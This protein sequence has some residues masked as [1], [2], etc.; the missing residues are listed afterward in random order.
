MILGITGTNGA[1]KGTV[2]EYLVHE[3]GFT[4]YSAR[5]EIVAEIERRGLAVSRD[6]MNEV[7]TA[8]RREHGPTYLSTIFMARAAESGVTDAV[9]ESIRT[10]A[11]AENIKAKGGFLLVVDADRRLRYERIAARASATDR[12]SFEEF[13]AQEDREM[14]SAEPEN[15]AVMNMRAVIAMADATVRN[16]GTVAELNAQTDAA[17]ARLASREAAA[18]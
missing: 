16:E 7:G 6:T 8:L 10:V 11:E 2:V 18:A 1:G 9:I 5:A 17:L 3:K 4:H 13:C 15:P 14:D 12:V